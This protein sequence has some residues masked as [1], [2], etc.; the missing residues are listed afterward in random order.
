MSV[1][2]VTVYCP[3]CLKRFRCYSVSLDKRVRCPYCEMAVKPISPDSI[4]VEATLTIVPAQ[5]QKQCAAVITHLDTLL[6]F[7]KREMTGE[8][9]IELIRQL[10]RS[11]KELDSLG[12]DTL[13]WKC[14]SAM[15]DDKNDSRTRDREDVVAFVAR[16][17]N[18]PPDHRCLLEASIFGVF[19]GVGELQSDADQQQ[20]SP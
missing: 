18:M 2:K 8:L 20:V 17:A 3:V 7:S 14:L 19:F 13:L 15:L 10:P 9:I 12:G 4:P 11:R 5:W 1:E 6:S 16:V